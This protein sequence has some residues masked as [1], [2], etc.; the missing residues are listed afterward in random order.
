LKSELPGHVI[1]ELNLA[2]TKIQSQERNFINSRSSTTNLALN[3][4][5]TWLEA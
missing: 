3:G 4:R 1:N 2:L 5:K